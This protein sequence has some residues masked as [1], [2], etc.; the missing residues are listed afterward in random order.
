MPGLVHQHRGLVTQRHDLD[1]EARRD[2]PPEAH[3]RP[4]KHRVRQQDRGD[5]R[6]LRGLEASDHGREH[7]GDDQREDERQDDLAGGEDDGERDGRRDTEEDRA[8]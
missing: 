3:Q 1:A 5:P 7:V 2:E 6:D 8:A 4:E